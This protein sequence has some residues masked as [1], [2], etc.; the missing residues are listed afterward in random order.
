MAS[1]RVGSWAQRGSERSGLQ[2]LPGAIENVP[3][4]VVKEHKING[5]QRT[6]VPQVLVRL[7]QHDL[8]TI[9]HRESRDSG[10]NR[11][12]RN[13]LEPALRC[14]LQGITR[15]AAQRL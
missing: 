9:L 8:R 5:F 13:G 14:E 4:L 3:R 15:G 7:L 1:Y 11:R 6:P 10:A 2:A 12:K